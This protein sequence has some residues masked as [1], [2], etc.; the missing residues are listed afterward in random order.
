MIIAINHKWLKDLSDEDY[1]RLPYMSASRLKDDGSFKSKATKD[2]MLLGQLI[3][4]FFMFETD[5][6]QADTID[7]AIY[8]RGLHLAKVL[9]NSEAGKIVKSFTEHY[10][11]AGM[12]DIVNQQTGEGLTFKAK[13]DC[14]P[15]KSFDYLFDLKTT[16][17]DYVKAFDQYGY[18]VQMTLYCM[19]FRKAE[20]KLIFIN[21]KT[22]KVDVMEYTPTDA[23]KAK[24][25]QLM[26]ETKQLKQLIND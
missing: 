18:D 26:T 2:A 9:S 5:Y 8:Q 24:V 7:P 20:A 4:H 1:Y 14:L 11:I 21:K 12:A 10:E 23:S 3:H 15:S 25:W 6:P 22:E 16:S 13:C 17:T 19:I